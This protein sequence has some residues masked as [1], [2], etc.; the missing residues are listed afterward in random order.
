M[1]I[2]FDCIID[3]RSSIGAL[4]GLTT[5]DRYPYHFF[6]GRILTALSMSPLAPTSFIHVKTARGKRSATNRR[7]NPLEFKDPYHTRGKLA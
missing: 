1:P 4:F 3:K 7:L 5:A 2:Y 6:D